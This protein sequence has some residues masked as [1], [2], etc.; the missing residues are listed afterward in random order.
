MEINNND[1]ININKFWFVLKLFKYLIC[2]LLISGSLVSGEIGDGWFPIKK[3]ESTLS[4]G[5]EADSSIWV[6]F[7][8][9]LG[10]ER[11]SCRLP[12]DPIYKYSLSGV[13][14]V[15]SQKEG[16]IFEL[17]AIQQGEIEKRIEEVRALSGVSLISVDLLSEGRASIAYKLNE[18]WVRESLVQTAHRLYLLQ[19]TGETPESANHL[20]F[21]TSF[22]V[23]N[24]I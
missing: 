5:E 2:S 6:L 23:E 4:E 8:K 24:K 21:V 10:E 15:S 18:K 20:A 17:K 9:N 1:I 11:I 12:E 3:T 22:Q 13:F 7:T 14:E 19:T 16:E